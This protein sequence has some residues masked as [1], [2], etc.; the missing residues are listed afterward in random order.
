MRR[1][2]LLAHQ[3]LASSC[4]SSHA[5]T[6]SL[7]CPSAG[8][9]VLLASAGIRVV[10]EPD[11]HGDLDRAEDRVVDV[12]H[13][14]AGACLVPLVDAVEGADLAGGTPISSRVTSRSARVRSAKAALTAALTASRW[15]TRS[16]LVAMPSPAGSMPKAVASLT[17]TLTAAGDLEHAVL[18][19]EQAVGRDRQVVVPW[20]WPTSATV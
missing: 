18:A 8:G 10:V 2:W 16:R 15:A 3:R 9:A 7:C 11:R 13:E 6:D 12:E 1:G 5:R 14:P 4:S 17:L 20:A 19:L